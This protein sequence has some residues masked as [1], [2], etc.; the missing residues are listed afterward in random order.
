NTVAMGTE[1][2]AR[3]H[4]RCVGIKLIFVKDGKSPCGDDCAIRDA[5]AARIVL[6]IAN[7]PATEVDG[8]RS[9]ILQL[10]C[11]LERQ[12]GVGQHFAYD[13]IRKRQQVRSTGSGGTW[14]TDN[15]WRAIREAAFGNVWLLCAKGYRIDQRASGAC[16]SEKADRFSTAG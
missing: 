1:R 13:Y 10:N 7:I 12:I 2:K 14:K 15:I 16:R 5:E 8:T 6:V 3:R 11:V 4:S 9:G